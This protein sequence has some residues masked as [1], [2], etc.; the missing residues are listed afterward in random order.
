M[1][2]CSPRTR[3]RLIS[4]RVQHFLQTVRTPQTSLILNVNA[5]SPVN[6]FYSTNESRPNDI[7]ENLMN[8]NSSSES[9]SSDL[10]F[11][12]SDTDSYSSNSVISNN[13]ISL[14]QYLKEWTVTHNITHIAL[15]YLLSFLPA[16]L[17]KDIYLP[18]DPRTLMQTPRKLEVLQIS[19]GHYI[20]FNMLKNIRNKLTFGLNM[21][22]TESIPILKKIQAAL[23]NPFISISIGVDGIP[24]SRSN[25]SQFWPILG[26][27]DQSNDRSPFVIGIFYGNSKP[28]DLDF[29][30]EFVRDFAQLER[31]GIH[32]LNKK[33]TVRI[34]SVIADAP[35]RS[36][37]KCVKNHNSY[38][39]CERCTV[40]GEWLGR[41]VYPI[42]NCH[43]RSDVTFLNLNDPDHHIGLSFLTK[44]TVGPISQVPLD[45]MHLVCLGVVRKLVRQWV[46]GKLK[47][48]LANKDKKLISNRLL[49]F[50][51][52][53]PTNFQR[54]PRSLWE[55]DHYKATELRTLLLYTGVS[56]F[57]D[58][59]P[60]SYYKNFLLLHSAMY[61][62]LSEKASSS[63]WNSLAKYLLLEFI[64]GVEQIY[65]SEFLIYNIHLL[66]H[67]PDD[68]MNYGSLN[69]VNA[70][71]S[72][73]QKIK[74]Y[75]HSSNFKLEQVANRITEMESVSHHHTDLIQIDYLSKKI[76]KMGD[77]CFCLKNGSI[78]IILRR[79]SG[80][81]CYFYCHVFKNWKKLKNIRLIADVWESFR[82]QN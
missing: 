3:R 18:R 44:L 58:I 73:M 19:G 30:N 45:Y 56:A 80:E 61:I 46:K 14:N 53:F 16:F 82:S 50:R 43:L 22:Y 28:S 6:E 42:E 66:S 79:E 64:R 77:N 21:A 5:L 31:E 20:H 17:S 25:N 8:L 67:I 15:K 48:R 52:Y 55:I 68:A 26:K 33:Y 57:K 76:F 75:M 40:H 1:L 81:S 39:S 13:H 23:E 37:L 71:E 63:E 7:A 69:N 34:S 10:S 35:A 9:E 70:F 38:N 41:V 36:F 72:F 29:M 47:N 49:S 54:K 60:K 62:L 4:R 51:K 32:F 27:I 2:G 24:A 59:I 78:I 74:K 65:G 12:V 11:S